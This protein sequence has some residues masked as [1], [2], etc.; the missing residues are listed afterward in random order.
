M[1]TPSTSITTGRALSKVRLTDPPPGLSPDLIPLV[2]GGENLRDCS[3]HYTLLSSQGTPPWVLCAT[4]CPT[5]LT[6][7]L[8]YPSSLPS[9]RTA[10]FER[11]IDTAG[12]A[13]AAV[14]GEPSV[15][16]HQK[17]EIWMSDQLYARYFNDSTTGSHIVFA[18]A[19]LRAVEAKKVEL[20]E[21]SRKNE[22]N[23]TSSERRQLEF[24]RRRGSIP[25]L[26]AAIAACLEIILDK[27]IPN[28]SRLSFEPKTSPKTAIKN[29]SDIIGVMA[30]FTN[31]LASAFE[32][33]LR[34]AQAVRAAL[35]VFS[36]LVES[37]AESNRPI[38]NTFKDKIVPA[39][40]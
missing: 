37:T 4:R 38:F 31:Q 8:L 10:I 34:N 22:N 16:Y 29:W 25:L 17:T 19:L 24:F 39:T 18:F 35:E 2:Y 6:R 28:L 11:L 33:G 7:R 12:Q 3:C 32:P 14:N 36:S 23:M 30:P 21:K 27:K 20:V 15:A 9:M 26:T 40:Q 13:L 1:G 5:P